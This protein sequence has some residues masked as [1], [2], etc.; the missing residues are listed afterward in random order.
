MRQFTERHVLTVSEPSAI[1][2]VLDAFSA[3]AQTHGGVSPQTC[4]GLTEF[5]KRGFNKL[6]LN[7][8][9]TKT[10]SADTSAAP[11]Q[12]DVCEMG[13]VLV[14]TGQVPE[15]WVLLAEKLCHDNFFSSHPIDSVGAFISRAAARIE[16]R[17][18][19]FSGAA[20]KPPASPHRSNRHE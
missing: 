2:K 12:L 3:G 15:P 7:L 4:R 11:M 9:V 17:I 10:P 14:L 19:H 18:L 8:R 16:T 5:S 20:E 13:G 6:V 1:K